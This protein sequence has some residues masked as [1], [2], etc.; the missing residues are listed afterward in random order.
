MCSHKVCCYKC[1]QSWQLGKGVDQAS[2]QVQNIPATE[3]ERKVC[4]TK[5]D[6]DRSAL[7]RGPA[8]SQGM[9]APSFLLHL[10]FPVIPQ[11]HITR[12]EKGDMTE[13]ED[14][15]MIGNLVD[16]SEVK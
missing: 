13:K 14:D 5:Q 10:S 6:V 2:I 1:Q 9:S 12:W 15:D 16:L 3:R 11:D 8:L 7:L 4:G